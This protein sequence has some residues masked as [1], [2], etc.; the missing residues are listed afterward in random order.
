MTGCPGK[1]LFGKKVKLEVGEEEALILDLSNYR[2]LSKVGSSA[3]G[4]SKKRKDIIDEVQFNRTSV[5]LEL[6]VS[7]SCII[8]APVHQNRQKNCCDLL[9]TQF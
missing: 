1:E 2:D 6:A 9:Q 8:L 5:Y 4:Q 7:A 3:N